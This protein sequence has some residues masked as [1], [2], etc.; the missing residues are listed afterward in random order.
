MRITNFVGLTPRH[1]ARL[2]DPKGAQL[3]HNLRPN[4]AEFQPIPE[5]TTVIANTSGASNPQTLFRF[6]RLSGGT[7]NTDFADVTKWRISASDLSYAKLPSA[8][9][10]SD[11][12][13]YSTNDGGT[14]PRVVDNTGDDRL[15]GVP[16]PSTAPTVTV[17]TVDEFTVEERGADIE[18]AKELALKAI[19]DNLTPV[20]RGG[21]RPGT[22]TTG[23]VDRTTAYGFSQEDTRQQVRA[24]R[25]SGAGGSI[26]DAYSSLDDDTFNWV[27]DPSLG[28]IPWI[29]A[30][31]PGWAGGAGSQHI[32]IPF[33]A[34][35]ITYDV[36]SSAL[37]TT[38]TAIAM[39]GKTDGT[40]LLTAPQVTAVVAAV[41]AVYDT[42]GAEVKPRLERLAS[43]VV[44]LKALLD[45]GS[46]ASVAAQTQTF[47]SKTDVSGAITT[48]INSFAKNVFQAASGVARSSL[49]ADYT[50]AGGDP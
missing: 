35:G 38:L 19:K 44:S 31:S 46:R 6:Q 22:G 12:H 30:A 10:S 32:V 4:T 41:V 37:S 5:D 48:A 18:G 33:P 28:A 43:A 8:A 2:L 49:P 13:A 29:A 36:N 14:A 1:A 9:D 25:L 40:K 11:R 17:T 21:A 7:L 27:F 3:A 34:Y 23:Y 42:T 26:A 39:P 50:G 45:G 16:T 47:Y 20:W 15:L 24:Y